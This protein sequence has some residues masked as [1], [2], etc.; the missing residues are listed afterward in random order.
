[1]R[2]SPVP[3]S[4]PSASESVRWWCPRRRARRPWWRAQGDDADH[5]TVDWTK[6]SR[7]HAVET[8]RVRGIVT[9]FGG[10]LTDCLNVGKEVADGIEALGVPL[11]ADLRNWYGEPAEASP[12]RVLPSGAAHAARRVP[13]QDRHR[14]A[15][16]P[17]LAALRATRVRHARSHSRGP[18]DGARRD[19]LGR[20][21]AGGVVLRRPIG[22][23]DQARGLHAAPLEDRTGRARRRHPQLRRTVRRGRDPLR[24]RCRASVGRILRRR[25]CS[26]A[27]GRSTTL[28][29]RTPR[30]DR[31]DPQVAGGRTHGIRRHLAG[32]PRGTVRA[33]AT[34]DAR[35]A[36]THE[37]PGRRLLPPHPLGG[38]QRLQPD[39]RHQ[40]AHR[41]TGV[42]APARAGDRRL[43][44]AHLGD[45]ASV[46]GAPAR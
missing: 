18:D 15:H 28:R 1:M 9:I 46:D 42:D 32:P 29:I 2:H 13:H 19:G 5:S 7:K 6:L 30:R 34:A 26:P 20:L 41:R 40:G 27:R 22:D 33:L 43:P 25:R 21:P 14:T 37:G 11:E 8:D 10:K 31:V 35:R 4:S 44:A 12:C 36:G 24:R 16:R 39:R 45:R 3:T 17:A 23:G 38:G